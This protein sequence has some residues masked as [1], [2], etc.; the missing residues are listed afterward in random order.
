MSRG[1]GT[2][3]TVYFTLL[4]CCISFL[5]FET[6]IYAADTSEIHKIHVTYEGCTSEQFDQYVTG[7]DIRDGTPFQDY[8]IHTL[9]I[10]D[11]FYKSEYH[12]STEFS[13]LKVPGIINDTPEME[14]IG[15]EIN[16]TDYSSFIPTLS[17]LYSMDG[18]DNAERTIDVDGIICA[19]ND[20]DPFMS[21]NVS[22]MA[23]SG[24]LQLMFSNTAATRDIDIHIVFAGSQRPAEP[25]VKVSED[26]Q[27]LG[28]ISIDFVNNIQGGAR[29]KLTASP[30][31]GYRLDK[32]T[33]ASGAAFES[34][35]GKSLLLDVTDENAAFT[36][37]F[38][39]EMN[40]IETIELANYGMY[41]DAVLW[42]NVLSHIQPKEYEDEYS[43][44]YFLTDSPSG[45]LDHAMVQGEVTTF[46]E[47]AAVT[48]KKTPA[49]AMRDSK[50]PAG[51][52]LKNIP[53]GNYY[54]GCA[55]TTKARTYYTYAPFN[56]YESADAYVK[57]GLNRII[58]SYRT[59]W[60]L[61]EGKYVGLDE[62]TD[63]YGNEW[64]AWIFTALGNNYRT[65]E[66]SIDFSPDGTFLHPGTAS[67]LDRYKA[68][69]TNQTL[70]KRGTK[71]L[72]KDITS[73]ISY[74]GDPRNMNGSNYVKALVSCFCKADGTPAINKTGK[75]YLPEAPGEEIDMLVLS[76]GILGLEIAG[77]TPK[78]GWTKQLRDACIHTLTTE[79][80]DTDTKRSVSDIYMMSLIP[81]YFLQ[82]DSVHGTACRS[83]LRNCKDLITRYNMGNNGA[84]Q[85]VAGQDDANTFWG[86]QNA[87]TAAVTVN[88]LVLA[89]MTAEDL[90]SGDFQKEYGSLLTSLCGEIVDG[91]V[92]YG[93]IVNRM[94]T[95]QTLGALVDLYN[96]KSCF[97]IAAKKYRKNYPQ[98]FTGQEE[99]VKPEAQKPQTQK[100]AQ[101]P[102]VKYTPAKA[103]ITKLIKGKK[104]FRIKWKK[105]KNASGYQVQYSPKKNFR[106]SV[107]TIRIGKFLKKGRKIG[108]LKSKKKYYVRIRAYR[109]IGSRTYYGKWSKVRRVKTK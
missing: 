82:D 37:C 100:P 105:T 102:K 7:G 87:N 32:V 73:I 48:E 25:T 28:T 21:G 96:G 26:Q 70:K 106:K 11:Y 81:M 85:Y 16:G 44:Q 20:D 2:S 79:M 47:E 92:L 24:T 72:F 56:V 40:P 69:A 3:I 41:S 9:T 59:E 88:T 55:A 64:E 38:R 86:C 61:S 71:Q 66:E 62:E 101:D 74:G 65:A 17:E 76:Y 46:S 80:A 35:D 18:W 99:A 4:L 31:P 19:E 15:L 6:P 77:A 58:D 42:L 12:Y 36:V 109:K 49:L 98:Y 5:L 23:Q 29:W 45:T 104:S 43:L 10:P 34:S 108:K 51:L 54:I 67:Y 75:V 8:G 103:K 53:A 39:E 33:D 91:G 84:M 50:Y 57:A 1:V 14:I 13:D 60:F 89:G 22:L 30:T 78:D 90:G 107:K 83:I 97:E 93:G 95:Y 27:G 94:A 68:A 63:S 52:L